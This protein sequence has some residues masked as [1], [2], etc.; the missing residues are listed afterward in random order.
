M[1][2]GMDEVAAIVL[3]GGRSQRMGQDKAALPLGGRTLLQRAVDA[4]SEVA[5]MVVIVGAPDRPLP[6][7]ACARPLRVVAD[8]VE[9]EGPLAGIVAGLGATDAPVA[10]IVGCDQPFVRPALLRLLARRAQEHIA[11]VP[12]MEGKPQP[13]C[14]AVRLDALARLRAVFEGG[15]R[16][17]MALTELPGALLLPPEQWEA[18]DPDGRSFIGVNTPDELARAEAHIERFEV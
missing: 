11:V 15:G 7:V 5:T 3:A 8:A 10:V 2:A 4:A 12:V 6:E 16:A 17:A 14:S 18:A 1:T 9:G 13:L